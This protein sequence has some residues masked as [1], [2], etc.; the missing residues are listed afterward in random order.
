L[1]SIL[2]ISCR[3]IGRALVIDHCYSTNLAFVKTICCSRTIYNKIQ[4]YSC[5]RGR[6]C[7]W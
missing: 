1:I 2:S 7:S 3:H 5:A 6:D 4:H